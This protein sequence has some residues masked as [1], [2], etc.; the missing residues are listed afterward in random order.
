MFCFICH[1]SQINEFDLMNHHSLRTHEKRFPG[2]AKQ[3]DWCFQMGQWSLRVSELLDLKTL[4]TNLS[5]DISRISALNF[6]RLSH[7]KYALSTREARTNFD[8]IKNLGKTK[9][10]P[11]ESASHDIANTFR[12][13][14]SELCNLLIGF[15][16]FADNWNSSHT[17]ARNQCRNLTTRFIQKW[18]GKLETF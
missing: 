16:T 11:A 9:Q 4:K 6:Y 7:T 8:K 15:R 5:L 12:S 14:R 3:K 17:V 2:V 1:S 18:Q 13:M 10:K